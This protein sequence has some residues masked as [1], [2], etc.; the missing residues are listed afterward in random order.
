MTLQETLI[1]N[2][3]NITDVF[4]TDNF[5]LMVFLYTRAHNPVYMQKTEYNHATLFF[6]KNEKLNTDLQDWEFNETEIRKYA[7]N[8][9]KVKKLID[10]GEIV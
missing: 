3:L 5:H 7:S 9:H 6:A 2:K 8:M 1:E 10:K 4:S